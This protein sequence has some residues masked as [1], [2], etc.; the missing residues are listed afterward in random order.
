VPN[1]ASTDSLILLIYFFF[2][3]AVGIS[4][5]PLLKGSLD[6]LQAGRA[7]PAWICG[8]AMTM[9]SLGSQELIGMGAAGARY[10]LVSVPFYLLGAV[11]VILFAGFFLVPVYHGSQARTLP[12]FLALR[13]G[14]NARVLHAGLFA[15]LA[16]FS[17]GVSLYAMARVLAALH[18]LETP[19]RAA[20]L[21]AQGALI[22][23]M[24]V[25]ALL[26]LAYLLL[27]G[28]TGTIYNLVIQF[29][30]IVAAWLPVVFLSLKQ[31]G[32]WS[33][34]KA[35]A[36][37][38]SFAQGKSGH[39]GL[40]TMA[41]AAGLGLLFAAGTWCADF[42]V[43]QAAM[44]A[45]DVKAARGGA[46]IAA[47]LRLALPFLL[48]LPAIAALSL[49]TPHTMIS[50]HSENGAIYHEITVVPPEVE[51]GEGLVPARLDAAGKPLKD[52]D[53][54]VVLDDDLAAPNM[55]V[56]LL[57][58]GLLGL[59]IAA[60]LASMMAGAAASLTAFSSVFVCDL[61]EPLAQNGADEQRSV[62]VMRW[63]AVAGMLLAFGVALA[64]MRF[65]SL[66]DAMALVSAVVIAPLLATLL[67]AVFW[68][69]ATG[70]GAFAGLIAG[71]IAALLHHGLA[72]PVGEQRGI[73]GGWIAVLHRPSS[74]LGFTIGTGV[75]AFAASLVVSAVVSLFTEARAEES[76][77]LAC[78]VIPREKTAASFWKKPETLAIAI[79]LAAIAV[80][81]GVELAW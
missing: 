24:A 15:A 33:G 36:G 71:A 65:G 11:P 53:G 16:L 39:A 72:L 73:H 13:F 37:L 51:N 42:R 28:L 67:V 40:A 64:A 30:V 35:A 18:V 58:T 19:L 68:S 32:G 9:A 61:W 63:A 38:S 57:P 21:E 29:F 3:L 4:L 74:E 41:S 81:A 59:G 25:P 60:L 31:A 80:S 34:L 14:Q 47:A 50:I 75:L 70:H 26:I 44:A 54:R 79:L 78:A 43:L 48:I 6:F 49:P 27:G 2:T 66:A 10:G 77:A 52:G 69:R 62:A 8:L 5:R 76:A 22:L 1:L 7:L 20:G 55:L 45:K 56:H 17:T 46:F 12:E 23:S